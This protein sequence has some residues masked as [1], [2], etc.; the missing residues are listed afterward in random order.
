MA[1]LFA[2][3][4]RF[5]FDDRTLSHVKIVISQKLRRRESFLLSWSLS[6]AG[7]SGRR[8]L[9]LTSGSHLHFRFRENRPPDLNAQWL[10]AM[11]E[12]ANGTRGLDLD[13]VPEPTRPQ[14]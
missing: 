9:W 4:D 3:K 2:G 11:V 5:D 14:G 10:E 7:G 6:A 8:S 12:S 13:A 1:T